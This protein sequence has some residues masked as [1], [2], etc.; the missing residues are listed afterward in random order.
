[1][2]K[3]LLLN[4]TY[5]PIRIIPVTRA[6]VLVLAEKAEVINASDREYHSERK[7]I[8]IPSVVRLRHFVEIPYLTRVKLTRSALI[9]RDNGS[10][11]YCGKTG[12][13]MNVD[14]ITPRSKGGKHRWE[15]VVWSCYPCNSKKADRTPAGAGMKLLVKPYVPK[16]RITLILGVG[17][18]EVDPQWEPYLAVA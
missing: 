11:G 12:D 4:A 18:V 13:H 5:E 16:D 6:I 14:H 15:N 17:K 8:P 10:C 3:T 2:H 1:L 9:K 7:A